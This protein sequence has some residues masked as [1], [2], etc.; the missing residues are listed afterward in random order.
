M[1]ISHKTSLIS[2]CF[3]LGYVPKNFIGCIKE[4]DETLGMF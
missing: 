3:K 4:T 2:D 1:K